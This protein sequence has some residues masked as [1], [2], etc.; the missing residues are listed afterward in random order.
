MKVY[1]IFYYYYP[2]D[3]LSQFKWKIL[4]VSIFITIMLLWYTLFGSAS[5]NYI[6][7]NP[8]LKKILSCI[9]IEN[10]IKMENQFVKKN[11]N[12]I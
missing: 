3:M 2:H 11:G 5:W 12:L 8:N 6:T 10:K 4:H 1:D 7:Y 9:Y